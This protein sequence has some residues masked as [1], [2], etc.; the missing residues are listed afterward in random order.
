[1]LSRK[2]FAPASMSFAIISGLWVAGPSVE[3]I[4][5]F[6]VLMGEEEDGGKVVYFLGKE[7]CDGVQARS[8]WKE[9]ESPF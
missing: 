9:S 7:S 3:M 2:T 4:F 8:A 6:R 1:M 5:V